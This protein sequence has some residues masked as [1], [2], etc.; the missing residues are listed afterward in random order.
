MSNNFQKDASVLRPL[1]IGLLLNF[2]DAP[3]S[4]KC[5]Y[6]LLE[7]GVDSVLVIDNSADEGQ[8][9]ALITQH[10]SAEA[11]VVV[12]ISERNLGF[13]AGANRGLQICAQRYPGCRVLLI[14][15]DA[16]L[17]TDGLTRLSEA[18]D[19]SPLSKFAYP[20]MEQDGLVAGPAYYQR[21]TG[22]LTRRPLPGAFVYASGCCLLID[23]RKADLPL[24]DER[25]FMYGE[26]CE[27][28]WRLAS[29]PQAM[30]Y[31]PQARVVHEGSASSGVGSVFYEERM[32]A[33][34]W[35]LVSKL[36]SNVFERW[37]MYGLRTL[38][39]LSRGL[40]RAFRYRSLVPLRAIWRGWK[41]A[42]IHDTMLG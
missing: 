17:L 32:V 24:F 40:L 15:N 19:Q 21:L 29:L 6:S 12:T 5:V 36:S 30:A 7:Q 26:D 16:F 14:N 23:T 9:G 20:D 10:F 38:T 4:I 33:A 13:S 34:H 18:L 25:F 39:L 35:M 1:Q 2:R 37:L 11:R 27:L 41:I 28:G 22:L 31:V 8:S 42:F 3:R